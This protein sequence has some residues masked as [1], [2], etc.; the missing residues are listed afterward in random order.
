MLLELANRHQRLPKEGDVF[1]AALAMHNSI[2]KQLTS[3]LDGYLCYRV[4]DAL[5]V[6]HEAV[7]GL[8]CRELGGHD[9]ALQHDQVIHAIAH[10]CSV[11]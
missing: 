2:P 11:Q 5:A 8:V 7:L 1:E 4:R 9:G 6:V 3:V 10:G